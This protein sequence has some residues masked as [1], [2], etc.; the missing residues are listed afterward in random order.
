MCLVDMVLVHLVYVWVMVGLS[1]A[2]VEVIR[3]GYGWAVA[4]GSV[5]I[6][7]VGQ[8]RPYALSLPIQQNFPILLWQMIFIMGMLAGAVFP[9][10]DALRTR[11]KVGLA[12]I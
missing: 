3:R 9:K 7:A 5:A 2:L 10:W 4:L 1:P 11:A 12:A 8:S 6:F